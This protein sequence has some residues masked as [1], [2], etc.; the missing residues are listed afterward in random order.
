MACTQW[1]K[2]TDAGTGQA[3]EHAWQSG[4][5]CCAVGS[6]HMTASPSALWSSFSPP[7]NF[8]GGTCRLCGSWFAASHNHMKVIGQDTICADLHDMGPGLSGRTLEHR[9]CVMRE[10]KTRLSDSRV[11]YKSD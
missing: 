2:Y 10:I 7:S 1:V 9:T 4:S 3:E 6:S 8:V 11:G 5:E